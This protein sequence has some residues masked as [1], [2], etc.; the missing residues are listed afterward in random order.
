MLK[1]HYD[2][3]IA[4]CCF[5]FLFANLGLASTA[6]SVHQPYIVAIPGVGDSG[7]S[8]ILSVRTAVSLLAMLFVD[9]YYSVLDVR[10]GVFL[11]TLATAC[12]FLVYSFA[13]S[14][15]VF[16]AGA[17]FLGLGYGLGG[18]VAVTYIANRWFAG[19][20][21]AMIG[22]ASMGSGVATIVMPVVVLQIIHATSL[23]GAFRF[24]AA[25]AAAV[26][27]LVVLVLRNR[28]SDLGIDPYRP[29]PDAGGEGKRGGKRSRA[30]R[31]MREAPAGE[32]LLLM[33]SMT[34]VGIFSCCAITYISVLATSN[35]FS[36]VLAALLVSIAGI[37]LTLS[38]FVTGELFD[39]LGGAAATAI[40]FA[41]GIAGYVLCCA[42]GLG[43]A[44]IMVAGAVL[45]GAGIS[46]GS[47]GV[48]VWSIDL[49]SRANRDREIR[50]FQVAY[51]IGAFISN[52]L[53]GFIKD[54]V[55]TYVASYAAVAAVAALAAF[56]ILRYYLRYT[57]RT[58]A[59]S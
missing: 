21:G 2:K 25:L 10:W 46:L 18:M 14:L 48:S 3:I 41:I 56:I 45:M 22:F 13:G 15:P 54:A 4:G 29:A 42:A 34:G 51:A 26:G 17:V 40:L 32:H 1:R 37:A 33:V 6:F 49:S 20:L 12:G 19:G 9:R 39:H 23:A 47:V 7:G 59:E 38:K 50:N 24:E 57:D 43:N 27:A 16:L 28:P 52:T 31:P 8:L 55:G 11:A 30:H 53:P 58:A 5:L 35:G 44:G 36:P